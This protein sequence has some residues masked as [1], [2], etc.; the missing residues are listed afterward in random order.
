MDYIQG[1][2]RS[3]IVLIESS[4]E[5]KIEQDNPV[6]LIDKFVDS[7]KLEEL[8]FTHAKHAPEG[9]PP[10]HPGDLLKLYIYGYLNRIRTTRLLE[11]EC[12]RNLELMWLLKELTPDHNTIANFRK[13]NPKAIKLVF[14]RMV[15]MCKR[16][17]LI[18]GKVIAIDGT[19][20]RAQNSKKNN[21]NQKKIDDHLGYIESRLHEYL[22]ALDIADAAEN[23]GLD[24]EIDK[25]K[26]QEKIARLNDK[27]QQYKK[28]SI[29]WRCCSEF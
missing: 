28:N 24:P 2:P 20:L 17:D 9:R 3:Q 23:M 12:K 19:K 4:M 13:A 16:L 29:S 26:I 7:C 10:Y 18:G 27:K 8:G 14:R 5:E 1:K 15:K 11:K 21:Y 25:K 6:R 22:D